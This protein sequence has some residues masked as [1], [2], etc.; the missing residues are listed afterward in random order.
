MGVTAHQGDMALVIHGEHS[1]AGR[2]GLGGLL[3]SLQVRET[4]PWWLME[5]TAHQGDIALVIH[6]DH[7]NLGKHSLGGPWGSLQASEAELEP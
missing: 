6:G 1:N 2:H 5:V 3:G 7:S 4:W